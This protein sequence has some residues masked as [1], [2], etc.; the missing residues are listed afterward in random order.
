MACVVCAEGRWSEELKFTTIAGETPDFKKPLEVFALLDPEKYILT[1]PAVPADE[2]R[3]SCV[4]LTIRSK[5]SSVMLR[6][7]RVS[8]KMAKGTEKAPLCQERYRCHVKAPPEMPVR[9]LAN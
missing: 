7:R 2:L 1:W 5:T 4:Q 3:K 8:D 6:Q 9:A